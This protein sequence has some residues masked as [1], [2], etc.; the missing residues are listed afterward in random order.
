M[1]TKAYKF[2]IKPNEQQCKLLQR[3]FGCVRF[4]YNWGLDKKIKHYEKSKEDGFVGNKY[5]TYYDLAKQL[6]LE[7][8]TEEHSFLKECPNACLQ[9]SLRCLETAFKNF[10]DDLKKGKNEQ[11]HGYPKFKSKNWSKKVAKFTQSVQFDFSLNMVKI[12][13]L[14]WIKLRANRA[15]DLEKCKIGTLTLTQNS[16]GK[17]YVSVVVHVEQSCPP[18]PKL[19]KKASIGID[20][21]IKHYATASKPIFNGSY[22]FEN[23]KFFVKL[24]KKMAKLQSDL[25]KK[26]KGSKRWQIVHDKLS[27]LQEKVTNCRN[28]F[29]H[30]LTSSLMKSSYD[31]FVLE[32]LDVKG[33]MQSKFMSKGIQDAAWHEFRRQMIYKSLWYGKNTVFISRYDASSQI[34]NNCGYQYRDLTLSMREWMCPEC[35][36]FHDR[37]INAA[38]NNVDIYY[39]KI[40]V[41]READRLKSEHQKVC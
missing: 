18:K 6:T 7:K 30:Q 37:D 13:K 4:I 39:K 27:K 26:T 32:D 23:P 9:Q 36:H 8:Q 41:G 33:M 24:E 19:D 21:G 31:T 35:G 3:W 28:N 11:K 2:Q 15:F 29:I 38:L 20:L 25:K 34:C 5:L 10:F 40:N 12:P 17:Y 14:G 22:F 1:I 16:H